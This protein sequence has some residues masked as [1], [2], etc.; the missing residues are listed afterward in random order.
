MQLGKYASADLQQ[1]PP[2]LRTLGDTVPEFI[3]KHARPKN[4]DWR[5]TQAML[6][7]FEPLFANPLSEIKRANV[8]RVL[9]SIIAEGKPYRANRVLAAIKKLFAW[10]LDR[11]LIDVHPISASG[12]PARRLRETVSSPSEK[13]V[14]SGLRR[15]KWAFPSAPPCSSSC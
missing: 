6:R 1:A 10:A 9:D 8:V 11:G 13:S 3:E 4:R 12:R 5:A 14:L 15:A 2:A 7:R